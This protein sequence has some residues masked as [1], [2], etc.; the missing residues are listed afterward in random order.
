MEESSRKERTARNMEMFRNYLNDNG[1]SYVRREGRDAYIL[2]LQGRQAGGMRI[3]E[4]KAAVTVREKLVCMDV[5]CPVT[6][7]KVPYM[8]RLLNRLNGANEG[9]GTYQYDKRD[10]ELVFSDFFLADG[11][12]PQDEEISAK[13][14]R[15]IECVLALTQE[16]MSSEA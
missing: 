1:I 14:E 2:R 3:R 9:S 7:R 6:S 8:A 10:G 11:G 4:I 13:I 16:I 5:Y 12:W 15:S